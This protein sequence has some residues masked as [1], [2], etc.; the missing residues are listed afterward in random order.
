MVEG[1]VVDFLDWGLDLGLGAGFG[2]SL[3]ADLGMSRRGREG[4]IS[5]FEVDAGGR[6][7][8]NMRVGGVGGGVEEGGA[9]TIG[10]GSEGEGE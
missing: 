3:G 7:G 1:G 2:G 10:E 6:G 4:T 9:E 5:A 8:G